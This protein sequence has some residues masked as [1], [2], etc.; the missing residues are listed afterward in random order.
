MEVIHKDINYGID[1][2]QNLENTIKEII[3][4][5]GS[6]EDNKGYKIKEKVRPQ[7]CFT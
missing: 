2:L 4:L 5:Q 7:G 1:M 6:M 3:G